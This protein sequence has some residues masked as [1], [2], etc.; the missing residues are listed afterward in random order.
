MSHS[1]NLELMQSLPTNGARAAGVFTIEDRIYLAVPQLARDIPGGLVGINA[2]NSNIP[3]VIYSLDE[4][5]FVEF[6]ELDVPGGEDAEFFVIEKRRFLATAS[7]RS[8][9]D[10]YNLDVESI[11]FEWTG[12]SFVE[13]QRIRTFAA[14][15]WRYFRVEG[16]HF[17]ALAQGADIPGVLASS[18]AYSTIFEWNSSNF[19]PFQTVPSKWGYNWVHFNLDGSDFLGYADHVEPSILLKWDN[20]KFVHHQVLDGSAG[21]AFCFF[22]A[23]RSSFLAFARLFSESVVYR[24]DGDHF[25]LHQELEGVGGREFAVLQQGS[26]Q[27]LVLVRFMTGSQQDPVVALDSAIYRVTEDG[28]ALACKI[29]TRGATDVSVFAHKN[30]NY[31]VITESLNS[32]ITFRTDTHVYRVNVSDPPSSSSDT[33]LGFQSLE[34]QKMFST[35]TASPTSIGSKLAK[36]VMAKNADLPL[37]VATSFDMI[38]YPGGGHTPSFTN[39][40][41]GARGFKELAA[42]SHLGPALASLVKMNELGAPVALLNKLGT[43]LLAD[44]EA[45]RAANS[46]SLWTNRIKVEAFAGREAAIAFMIDY[47]LGLTIRFLKNVLEDPSK[48]TDTYLRQ[49]YL[50]ATNDELGATIP[51]NAVMIATFFLVGLDISY[52]VRKWI[53]QYNIDWTKAMVLVTGKQ[54]RATSGVTLSTNSVAQMI[55]EASDLNLSAERLYIAPHGAVPVLTSETTAAELFTYEST[56]R[57]LWNS[58]YG[59]SELGETMFSGYASYKPIANSQPRISV[60]TATVSELPKIR[61]TNDWLS[62]TTRLRIVLEDARQLLS[63]CVTDYAAEQLRVVDSDITRVV[64]PGLDGFQYNSKQKGFRSPPG[65]SDNVKGAYLN[66]LWT[67]DLPLPIQKVTVDGGEIAY[68]ESGPRDRSTILWVPGLPLDS[69][70]WTCQHHQ[71][72]DSFHNIYIDMRGYGHSSKLP[73]GTSDVTQL[74]CDDI[75]A[76]L[77]A[78]GINNAHLVGFASAGHVALRFSAQNPAYVNRL[79][80]MN[81]SP[82]FLKD[83]GSADYDFGFSQSYIQNHFVA[84]AHSSNGLRTL[85]E[86]ILDPSLVFQE[87]SED[88]RA[89][90]IPWMREMSYMA[91]IETL[92]G[93]FEHIVNDDDRSLVSKV[94]AKTLLLASSLGK[95]VPTP[96][97]IYL[98]QHLPNATLVEVP[99]SDHFFPVTRPTAVNQL[100][101]SFLGHE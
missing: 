64:V 70:F 19:Q 47:A 40:R 69:R 37:L 51:F 59:V 53:K 17:L 71:F 14:K 63:G 21:R 91:G 74:Y 72:A 98:R 28:L 3:L 89:I 65:P 62:M 36:V 84:A 94:K 85:T 75:L 52:R 11:I 61:D 12:S 76:V 101:M 58:L 8:G 49:N 96:T 86:K 24:W 31:T 50:N 1:I 88:E 55:L 66:T 57:Q 99:D 38:I 6:Q 45:S 67:P 87:L 46:E 32:D 16:R 33:G 4:D 78:L 20:G 82:R 7:L 18:S 68:R 60:N 73:P 35:Y 41:V 56:F 100:I 26:E 44:C 80:L 29:P 83:E 10:P 15:Q 34:F 43:E 54:G 22:S 42:T 13:F 39:F 92:C 77:K 81:A 27:F 48:L 79:V 5:K 9:S 23:G 93:F 30:C 90:I 95:E 2:G 97:A 25:V